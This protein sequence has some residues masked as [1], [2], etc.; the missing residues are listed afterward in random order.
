MNNSNT[1]PLELVR[2]LEGHKI[3][4][5]THNFPDPDAISTAYG[6]QA[7]LKAYNIYSTICYDGKI[8]QLST[9]RMLENFE[10]NAFQ[11]ENINDMTYEDY[12]VVVDGQKYNSNMTDLPGNE[13]ACI[14]HHPTMIDCDYKYKDV[15]I[16]GA[17]ASI[18][19]SYFKETNTE[20]PPLVA[21]ALCYGIKMD[22]ADFKRG[23]TKFDVSMFDYAFQVAIP[24]KI[25]AMY[26]NIMEFQD[27]KAYAAAIEDIKVYDR[28]G[29]ACIPFAC[30]DAMIAIIADFILSLDVVDVAVIYS[31]RPN[32]YKFSV[33]SEIPNVDAGQMI[34]HALSGIGSGGGHKSMAGGFIPIENVKKLGHEP[35][36]EIERI[37]LQSI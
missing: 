2:L 7:F 27:L 17:C 3:Y 4:I 24:E 12:V 15:R 11:K 8:D 37:F 30:V 31:I 9:S 10:L 14:D 26:S 36:A 6:L 16:V 32:G 19:I 25:S 1:N 34:N 23:T 33:R 28:V 29:F 35:K 13:V 20:L 21:S 22:T 18:I 5:Q